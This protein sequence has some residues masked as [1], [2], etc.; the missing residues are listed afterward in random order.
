MRLA[1]VLI[2]SAALAAC[3][4]RDPVAD[5]ADSAEALPTLNEADPSPTGGPPPPEKAAAANE[6]GEA[7]LIPAAIHGRWG[8]SPADCISTRGDAKGLLE[9]TADRLRF[10]ESVAVPAPNVLTTE[11]SVGGDF[12]FTGEGQS[13]SKYQSLRLRHGRL[14]RTERDPVAS[15][16]YVR[17]D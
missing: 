6:T 8:L 5:E 4:G 14:V 1:L 2:L 15:F 16:R 11:T 7:S 10:Y 17:C 13:W 9:I 3:G 12:N